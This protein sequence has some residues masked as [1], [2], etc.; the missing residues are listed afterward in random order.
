MES[1]SSAFAYIQDVSF[2]NVTLPASPV[3]RSLQVKLWIWWRTPFWV[4]SPLF[5]CSKS[6]SPSPRR[7]IA[8]PSPPPPQLAVVWCSVLASSPTWRHRLIFALTRHADVH[9]PLFDQA[10]WQRCDVLERAERKGLKMTGNHNMKR[11]NG[12]NTNRLLFGSASETASEAA[13][14]YFSFF[15]STKSV[16]VSKWKNHEFVS[17]MLGLAQ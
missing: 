17:F 14:T 13:L 15:Q 10:N 9:L 12:N 1:T 4:H 11:R 5:P 2:A 7:A 8:N 6:R 3:R 16:Y